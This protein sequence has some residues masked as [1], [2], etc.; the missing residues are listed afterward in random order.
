MDTAHILAVPQCTPPSRNDAKDIDAFY[1]TYGSGGI[2]ALYRL[3]R[4]FQAHK[5]TR[6]NATNTKQSIAPTTQVA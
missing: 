3:R 5:G 1:D 4:I 6:A 2:A